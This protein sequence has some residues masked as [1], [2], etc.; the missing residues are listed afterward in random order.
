MIKF[1]LVFLVSFLLVSCS[2]GKVDGYSAEEWR[3]KYDWLLA[4]KNRMESNYQEQ[5]ESLE[6]DVSSLEDE[7]DG[8]QSE[9]DDLSSCVEDHP[10]SAS[11]YCI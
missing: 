5:I 10:L 9:L 8:L 3:D 4:D 11:D 7:L 6:D 2:I 1:S